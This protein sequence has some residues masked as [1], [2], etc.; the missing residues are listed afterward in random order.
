MFFNNI[1]HGLM[2]VLWT[3]VVFCVRFLLVFGWLWTITL[4]MALIAVAVG[5]YHP[6]WLVHDIW[7]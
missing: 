3:L 5:L 4:L 1:Y 2:L 7:P 6:D